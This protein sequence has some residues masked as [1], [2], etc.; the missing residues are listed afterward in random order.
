MLNMKAQKH[1]G[2]SNSDGNVNVYVRAVLIW[3]V[4]IT[5]YCWP[6]GGAS[7]QTADLGLI[8][9]HLS[10]LISY[11]FTAAIRHTHAPLT[12]G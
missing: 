11:L 1:I 10:S 5:D 3:P 12:P 7:V 6:A 8:S 9:A 4:A 2:D